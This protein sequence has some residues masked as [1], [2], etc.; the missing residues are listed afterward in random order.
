MKF[1]KSQITFLFIV[2]IVATYF[3]SGILLF[4]LNKYGIMDI[5]E[6]YSFKT[7]IDAI[8][9]NYDK[10]WESIGISFIVCTIIVMIL[11]FIKPKETIFGNARFANFS[12]I[13]KRGLFDDKGI[14]IGKYKNKLLRFSGQQFVALGAPTRSG[15]GVGIVIPN[16][17]EWQDSCVV[18]D[19][20]QEC[21]DYTS[22][23]RRDILGQDVYLFNPFSNVTDRYNPLDY[24]D[25][26]NE[27]TRDNELTNFANLLY[28][29]VS[30]DT[31]FDTQAVELFLGACYMYH[32]IV[33]STE[34]QELMQEYNIKLDFTLNTIYRLVIRGLSEITASETDEET[35]ETVEYPTQGLEDT[36]DLLNELGILSE[37]TKEHIDLYVFQD[38]DN[39]KGGIRG[40]FAGPLAF[41]NT[42]SVKIAT[43]TSD[44]DL[45]DLRKKKMTI[46]IG[47]TPDKLADAKPILNIFWSQLI[48]LNTQELPQRNKDLKYQC[49]L[50]MDEFTS[51][52]NM[53]ILEKAVSFIAGY[54]LRLLTIFQV[55][56][57]LRKSP[58]DG[59]GR[60]GADTLLK[61][62]ACEIYYAP[63]KIEDA[64][65]ISKQ[66][67]DKTVKSTS[68]SHSS[69]RGSSSNGRNIS[70][71][72]R[73]LML[74]QE[75]C[76]MP[77]EEEIIIMENI[78]P[79]KANKALYYSDK[80]FMNKFKKVSPSLQK[81]KRIPS[82]NEFENAILNDEMNI[83]IKTRS[84]K[85]EDEE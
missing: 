13:K 6:N 55:I 11:P 83:K 17:L 30:K 85:N 64:E 48:S 44:F 46:Y 40:S 12:E 78:K 51:I 67:S 35:G 26:N 81:I 49:L 57:Q 21:F 8:L 65:P 39:T 4:V 36:Y 29:K 24:I 58:P 41:Y 38:S 52:G 73:A 31:F 32:D 80:Y 28:P 71:A 7:T 70:D 15:K 25:M 2:D 59:Y 63:K 60:E 37:I 54:N 56:S 62:H 79:F 10:T 47:I 76:E 75:I 1:N 68:R 9:N 5:I 23:Y 16:L 53:P 66:L 42:Q 84:L 33:S 61:N 3:L 43:A 20:K 34:G 18:Q 45:R 22:K 77:F 14:I 69:S 27:L 72:K 19:I 82:Q 74:P 50:L